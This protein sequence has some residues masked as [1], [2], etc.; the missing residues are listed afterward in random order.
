MG[1]HTSQ[2]F[3]LDCL[4]S[5]MHTNVFLR[6]SIGAPSLAHKRA[7]FYMHTYVQAKE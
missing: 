1:P 5:I 3:L 2:E 7:L 6:I 4:S